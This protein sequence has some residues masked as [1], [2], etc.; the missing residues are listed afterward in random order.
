[1]H[2]LTA[3][4]LIVVTGLT[5][6]AGLWA[7][8]WVAGLRFG[9]RRIVDAVKPWSDVGYS[10]A[11]ARAV[12]GTVG[13]YLGASLLFIVALLMSGED[14]FDEASMRVHVIGLGPASRAGILD[15]DRI[16]RVDGAPVHDW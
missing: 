13:W 12:G 10:M 5:L 11:L 3:F 6:V 9:R 4:V 16:V 14:R 15:N 2:A 7:G 1:M 8:R